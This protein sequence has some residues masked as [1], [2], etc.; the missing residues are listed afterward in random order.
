M[1]RLHL[2]PAVRSIVVAGVIGSAAIAG[3]S[4]AQAVPNSGSSTL[5]AAADCQTYWPTPYK[6]CGEIRDLYNS[7]GGPSSALSFPSGPEVTNP[8][9]NKY[10]TFLNGTIR[11]SSSTGAYVG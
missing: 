1:T 2:S 6:V 11:W 4:T 5:V 3:I 10:S 8:D 9:G 7:L